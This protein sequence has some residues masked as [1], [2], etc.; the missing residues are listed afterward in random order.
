[1]AA[2]GRVFRHIRLPEGYEAVFLDWIKP[3]KNESLA[4][5]ALRLAE[6]ID[7]SQPFAL[8]GLS[9]GGML[10]SEIAKRYKPAVTIL[11]SSIPV[12]THLPGYFRIAAKLRLHKLVPIGLLKTAS[13]VKR[14]FTRETSEDKKLIL[15]AIRESDPAMIRW[16]MHAILSW[17]NDCMPQPVCH[18]HGTSDE[19][20]PIK[21][22]QPTHAINRGGHMLVLTAAEKVNDIIKNALKPSA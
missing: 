12:S 19:V 22:T 18:I 5:Y 13:G 3:E 2:D 6:R 4:N 17:K 16:S 7:T 21:Y 15:Q 9:F 11:I 8:I 20:L 1:M 14:I 10:A